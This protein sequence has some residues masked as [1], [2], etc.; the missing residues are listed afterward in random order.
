MEMLAKKNNF[1]VIKTYAMWFDSTYVAML[2]EQYKTGKQNF[3]KAIFIGM[4]SNIKAVFNNK[5]CSSVI[6]VL[7]KF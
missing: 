2:S 4:L 5:N 1:K 7:E 3:I 6:Y